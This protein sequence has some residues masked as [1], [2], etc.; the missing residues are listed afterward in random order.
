MIPINGSNSSGVD[1]NK[2][3]LKN[4]FNTVTNDL[5]EQINNNKLS[6][7]NIKNK[8]DSTNDPYEWMAIDVSSEYTE[9]YNMKRC[10]NKYGDNL[11]IRSTSETTIGDLTIYECEDKTDYGPNINYNFI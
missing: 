8:V 3:V 7:E 4:V 11:L 6:I 5:S 9:E 1:L 2:Y 10:F